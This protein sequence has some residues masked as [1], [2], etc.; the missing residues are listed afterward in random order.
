MAEQRRATGSVAR[1]HRGLIEGEFAGVIGEEE[2]VRPDAGA[3][4]AYFGG[5]RPALVRRDRAHEAPR[6]LLLWQ[7]RSAPIVGEAVQVARRRAEVMDGRHRAHLFAGTMSC[8]SVSSSLRGFGMS[9]LSFCSAQADETA[10]SGSE[11]RSFMNSAPASSRSWRR[12]PSSSSTA[13]S[14]RSLSS[15]SFL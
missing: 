5:S 13:A 8:A 4:G 1:L 15:A 9:T 11:T 3:N 12:L 10:T 7:L 14:C 6:S 2:T